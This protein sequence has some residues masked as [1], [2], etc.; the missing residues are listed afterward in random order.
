M[1][2]YNI[3]LHGRD[4]TCLET[5]KEKIEINNV[6]CDIVNGELLEKETIEKLKLFSETKGIEILINNA[7][8]YLK[9]PF[10]ETRM[11]EF[12]KVIDTNLMAPVYLTNAVLPFLINNGSG[13]IVNINSIAG[14]NF[15]DGETAYSASKHALRGFS[16]S[17]QFDLTKYGIRL[18]DVYLGAMDTNMTSGRNNSDKLIKPDEVAN[19]IFQACTEYKS[20]RIRELDLTRRLY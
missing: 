6:N 12:K 7:G 19:I 11:D 20:V 10:L 1:N 5:V 17:L 18:I 4:R 9:K 15:S 16:G 3:I 2:N 8:I 14:K 13:V